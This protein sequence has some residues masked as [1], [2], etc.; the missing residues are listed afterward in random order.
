MQLTP[1]LVASVSLFTLAS[2]QRNN[3]PKPFFK[4]IVARGPDCHYDDDRH[5][6]TCW[7]CK[8]KNHFSRGL[9]VVGDIK[10]MCSSHWEWNPIRHSG[11]TCDEWDDDKLHACCRGEEPWGTKPFP[12]IEYW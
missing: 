7:A 4:T 1:I 3:N 10:D 11:W 8:K 12:H 5:R 2:A 6:C 9:F